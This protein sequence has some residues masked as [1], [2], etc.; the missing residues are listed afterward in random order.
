M[1]TANR[2]KAL[3]VLATVLLTVALG[4]LVMPPAGA[5]TA[6]DNASVS[7]AE[8]TVEQP[9]Y[10]DTE[11][12]RQSQD[13]I[14]VYIV[15][16][17]MIHFK[18]TNFAPEDVETFGVVTGAG[19][20]SFDDTWNRYTLD[21]NGETASFRVYFE[22]TETVEVGDGNQT[23]TQTRTERFEA[24]IRVDDMASVTVLSDS[25]AQDLRDDASEWRELNQTLTEIR[26]SDV[27]GHI[28]SQPDSNQEVLQA[29]INAYVTTRSPAH[30]LTG[31][32]T[33]GVLILSTTVGGLFLLGILKVPDLLIVRRVWADLRRRLDLEERE[34]DLAQRQERLDFEQRMQKIANWEWN[35]LPSVTDHEAH[36]L[37]NGVAEN[38]LSGLLSLVYGFAPDRIKETELLVMNEAGYA[39]RVDDDMMTD[40]GVGATASVVDLD[41]ELAPGESLADRDDLRPLD[42]TAPDWEELVAAIPLDD[43]TLA[44][45]DVRSADVDPDDIDRDLPSLTLRKLVEEFD[46]GEWAFADDERVGEILV[47]FMELV[48]DHPVTTDDGQFDEVRLQL[49]H[50]LQIMQFARDKGQ[51]P[52]ADKL[53]QHFEFATETYDQDDDLREFL[54][55][56][57]SNHDV[58]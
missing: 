29:A 27:V 7:A 19:A 9:D 21:T 58:A 39:A 15:S 47:E 41:S 37:R 42:P 40:G 45:F 57:R 53:A 5:Q 50:L 32:F 52:H 12:E 20:V 8:L 24:I 51:F 38:P 56:H 30:L 16:G 33:A 34:G 25:Q 3:A 13:G 44:E 43:P 22:V 6:A 2:T 14:P 11:V 4:T 17:E 35:D 1:T 10:V 54:D 49:E 48:N 23:T 31:G 36:E 28:F 26:N 46:F 55:N 18:P